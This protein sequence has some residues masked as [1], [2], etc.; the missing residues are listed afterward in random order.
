M[1]GENTTLK[2]K[3]QMLARSEFMTGGFPYSDGQLK[4]S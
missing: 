1:E 3:N 2:K 4:N